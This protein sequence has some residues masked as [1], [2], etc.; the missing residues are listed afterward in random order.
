MNYEAS[1]GILII[2]SLWVCVATFW[3]QRRMKTLSNELEQ[4]NKDHEEFK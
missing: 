3:W 1:I 2:F 4:I